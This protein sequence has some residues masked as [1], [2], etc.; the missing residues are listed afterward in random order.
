MV[1]DYYTH[2]LQ[3][4]CV[5]DASRLRM[6]VQTLAGKGLNLKASVILHVA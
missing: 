2:T 5:T 4:L 1:L 6:R 3:A